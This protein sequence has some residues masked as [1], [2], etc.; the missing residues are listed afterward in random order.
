MGVGNNTAGVMYKNGTNS[1]GTVSSTIHTGHFCG[2][3]SPVNI[4]LPDSISKSVL[5]ANGVSFGFPTHVGYKHLDPKDRANLIYSPVIRMINGEPIVHFRSGSSNEKK[6]HLSELYDEGSYSPIFCDEDRKIEEWR[7]VGRDDNA[8]FYFSP[9]KEGGLVIGRSKQAYFHPSMT[10]LPAKYVEPILADEGPINSFG[11]RLSWAANTKQD[12]R[13]LFFDDTHRNRYNADIDEFFDYLISQGYD[14]PREFLGIGSEVMEKGAGA[15]HYHYNGK[16]AIVSNSKIYEEAKKIAEN[17]GLKGYEAVKFAKEYIY[18]HELYHLFDR[19]GGSRADRETRTG[20]GLNKFFRNKAKSLAGSKLSKFY[21]ALAE[22]AEDYA[23]GWSKGK[24]LFYSRLDSL[25]SKYKAEAERH[26]VED[27]EEYVSKRLEEGLEKEEK[28]DC[29]K[30]GLEEKLSGNR[31]KSGK[32]EANLE[33][34][35]ENYEGKETEEGETREDLD[36]AEEVSE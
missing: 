17:R 2:K 11:K 5:F 1:L 12:F 27:V 19:E 9:E 32:R 26:N 36:S 8:V 21:A 13:N 18:F 15:G 24:S 25:I 23:E 35:Q 28:N 14:N 16:S 20:E 31:E 22:E 3:D 6:Y 34:E 4:T 7:K 10:P 29:K 30:S 33:E